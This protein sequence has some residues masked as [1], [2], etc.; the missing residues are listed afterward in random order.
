[1]GW[2]D[3]VVGCCRRGEMGD[4]CGGVVGRVKG[5]G[6]GVLLVGERDGGRIVPPIGGYGIVGDV[7]VEGG[8]ERGDAG[9][10]G[11]LGEK[12]V[13]VASL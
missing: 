4:R 11:L 5:R 10:V 6:Y 2:S 8:L 7:D 13:E 3:G 1:M 12:A 9:G